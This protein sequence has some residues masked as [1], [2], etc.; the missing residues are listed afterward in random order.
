VR[1]PLVEVTL[2]EGRTPD[3]LRALLRELHDAVVRAV[4][5]P[6]DSV[7]V[8]IREVPA[9]HWSAGGVTL[10]ERAGQ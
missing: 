5:A 10:A 9:T 6:P 7:R 4:D 8:I 3:Q 1:V 2:A